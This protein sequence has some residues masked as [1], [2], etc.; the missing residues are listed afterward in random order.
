M[1]KRVLAFGF[2]LTALAACSP[3]PEP[4]RDAPGV[5][6]EVA[7]APARPTAVAATGADAKATPA[8]AAAAD[9]RPGSLCEMQ[10]QMVWTCQ[11]GRRTISICASNPLNETEGYAQ[12][13]IGRPG[14]LEMEYPA[15]RVHPRGRFVYTTYP[16]GNQTLD[17]SNG[18]YDYRVFEEL[19]STDDGVYVE[20]NGELVSQI[21]CNGGENFEPLRTAMGE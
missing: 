10:E 8:S 16:Q 20:R 19:R 4:S 12:Y 7:D 6:V 3:A 17:F 2:A 21:T 11:A 13:R 5:A 18:G 14:A 15:T 9:L 1:M